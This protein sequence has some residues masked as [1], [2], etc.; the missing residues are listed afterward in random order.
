MYVISG[1]LNAMKTPQ[2]FVK[3]LFEM[4]KKIFDHVNQVHLM[5]GDIINM[6]G[7]MVE[8]AAVDKTV[9][10]G[11]EATIKATGINVLME[12]LNKF[13]TIV[14]KVVFENPGVK[15]LSP[16]HEA[17]S[18]E[19]PSPLKL[20]E[21]ALGVITKSKVFAVVQKGALAFQNAMNK[22]FCILKKY[23]SVSQTIKK[24]SGIMSKLMKPVTKL[25]NKILAIAPVKK[26][27]EK[28]QGGHWKKHTF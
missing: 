16:G 5:G 1:V 22:K 8:I 20:C 7:I 24:V 14:V 26:M 3:A 2:K 13:F 25:L 11:M 23:F 15:L 4:K 28:V 18:I 17:L 9:Q 19:N 27:F 10:K 6:V 21:A 12:T